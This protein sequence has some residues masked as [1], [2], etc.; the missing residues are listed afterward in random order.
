MSA[1]ITKAEVAQH[2]DDKSM[3]IIID[4]GVYEIAN[5]VNEHPGGAKILKR[6]AGKDATK[7]FW[8][9]HSKGVMEKWGAKLKVGTLKEEAKL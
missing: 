4:D 1:Q 7:Q 3:Y 8:K 9:Y 2:K 5:F 6:M